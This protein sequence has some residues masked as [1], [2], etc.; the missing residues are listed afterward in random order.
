MTGTLRLRLARIGP[1]NYKRFN[2]VA[3]HSSRPRDRRHF[4]VVGTYDPNPDEFGTKRVE[5]KAERVKYW[6]G[7]LINIV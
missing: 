4:E 2:I 1:K 6:L 3:T 5:I 7:R